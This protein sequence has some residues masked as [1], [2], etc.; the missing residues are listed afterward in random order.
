MRITKSLTLVGSSYLG[1]YVGD[2]DRPAFRGWGASDREAWRNLLADVLARGTEE[3]V[4]AVEELL[5]HEVSTGLPPTA[6]LGGGLGV[7]ADLKGFGTEALMA[8]EAH[9]RERETRLICGECGQKTRRL[10]K[11]TGRN[12]EPLV[13]AKC[14]YGT[15][16]QEGSKDG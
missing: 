9:E 15:E 11:L 12:D 7:L 3:Q 8:A 6:P 5:I 4:R 16:A 10:L 1:I 2:A 13:C 14:F